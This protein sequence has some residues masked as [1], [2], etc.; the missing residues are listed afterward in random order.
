[1]TREKQIQLTAVMVR[2]TQFAPCT[3]LVDDTTNI[4]ATVLAAVRKQSPHLESWALHA[5][6]YSVKDN[7]RNTK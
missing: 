7:V 3:V 5:I 2:G 1:M 6:R 4:H